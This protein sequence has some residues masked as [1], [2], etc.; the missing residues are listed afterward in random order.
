M[1]KKVLVKPADFRK[2][3]NVK[4]E[5]EVKFRQENNDWNSRRLLYLSTA[6]MWWRSQSYSCA[7]LIKGWSRLQKAVLLSHLTFSLRCYIAITEHKPFGFRIRYKLIY[8]LSNPV[9]ILLM[10]LNCSTINKQ[11]WNINVNF[12]VICFRF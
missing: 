2:V 12:T 4:I 3:N 7:R 6:I 8:S 1:L 5:V 10:G 9:F 11:W